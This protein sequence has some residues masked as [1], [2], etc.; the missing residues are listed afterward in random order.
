MNMNQKTPRTDGRIDSQPANL[1]G[2]CGIFPPTGVSWA[3]DELA[4]LCRICQSNA[5][6]NGPGVVL[7]D[8]LDRASSSTPR[9]CGGG[10]SG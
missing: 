8:L 1:C 7:T 5:E 3:I 10:R 4:E 6:G 2:E 9:R